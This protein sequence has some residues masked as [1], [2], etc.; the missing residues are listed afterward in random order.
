MKKVILFG[1]VAFLST[2]GAFGQKYED[3]KGML[4][5]GQLDKAKQ[6]YEKNSKNEK[7]F[8]KPEGYLIRASLLANEAVLDT[9]RS[10]AAAKVAEEANE[11]FQKYR[12]MDPSLKEL[13]DPVYK[14]IPYWIYASYYNTATP[15][16]SSQDNAVI[17]EGYNR[18]KNAVALSEFIIEN[19]LNANLPGPIDTALVFYTGYMAERSKDEAGIIKYYTLLADAKVNTS[20]DHKRIYQQLIQ[21]Y[22]SKNDSEN[23]NKYNAIGR[24]LF[25]NESYFTH[26]ILDFAMSGG[27]FNERVANLEKHVNANPEDYKANIALAEVIYDTLDSRKIGAVP[28]ANAEELEKKMLASLNKAASLKPEE[29]QPF[30]LLGDHYL[31]KSEKL[32]DDMITAETEV[33]RKANKATAEDKQKFADAKKAYNAVYELARE[34]YEKA[35][36]LYSKLTTL[37]APQK[38]IYRAIAGNL[39]EYYSYKIE[40]SKSAADRDKYAALEKKW[41]ALFTKLK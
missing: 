22:A 18:L 11:A 16:I 8:T 23:F 31:I 3:I 13:Q 34:N 39:T 5:I 27:D 33:T 36:N 29:T 9:T 14:N 20:E 7:F 21:Y 17:A 38:R 41:D 2:M 1:A 32:R 25:P 10:D 30:L 15:A 28:P 6:L 24:S 37:D 19:K 4:A 40:D 26:S 12:E 35:A